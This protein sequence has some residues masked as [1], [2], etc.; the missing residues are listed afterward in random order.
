MLWNHKICLRIPS[1]LPG[2]SARGDW[3]G[4]PR[5]QMYMKQPLSAK[6]HCLT[7]KPFSYKLKEKKILFLCLILFPV[8]FFNGNKTQKFSD[9][10]VKR[11]Q[12]F[13]MLLWVDFNFS[14]LMVAVG[15]GARP[16]AYGPHIV[17][18]KWPRPSPPLCDIKYKDTQCF[19]QPNIKKNVFSCYKPVYIWL[20]QGGGTEAVWSRQHLGPSGGPGSLVCMWMS[21][22]TGD[23]KVYV[24]INVNTRSN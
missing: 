13:H 1:P 7:K 12:I 24:K 3:A 21:H 22:E 5:D 15:C 14:E 8:T 19:F 6:S 23:W 17:N 11:Y 18:V 2:E 9:V 10:V 4:N 20:W 16:S